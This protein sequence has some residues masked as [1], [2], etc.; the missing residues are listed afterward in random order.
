MITLNE[1]LY[2]AEGLIR[3]CYK[4]PTDENLCIKVC[5]LEDRAQNRFKKEIIYLTK[6]QKKQKNNIPYSRYLGTVET[7]LGTGHLY[8]LI[9]DEATNELSKTLEFYLKN[10]NDELFQ[11]KL[12][13]AVFKL[14]DDMIHHKVFSNDL[15]SRNICCKIHKDDSIELI[16]VDGMGH[17]DFIPLADHIT[18]FAKKKVNRWFEK[19]DFY[20]NGKVH[21]INT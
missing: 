4:H 17:R 12:E 13:K 9:C 1:S 16:I 14:K 8:D 2:I 6:I 7:N 3:K 19:S 5:K 10:D 21:R 15:F 20:T 11:K 18:H